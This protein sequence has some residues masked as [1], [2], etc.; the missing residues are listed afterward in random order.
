MS[1]LPT[2]AQ[3]VEPHARRES[4]VRTG[5]AIA[6]TL[7]LALGA[8]AIPAQA[9]APG[10]KTQAAVPGPKPS[11][12]PGGATSGV[13]TKDPSPADRA[14]AQKAAAAAAAQGVA[15]RPYMGWSSWSLQATKYPGVN[16]N[17]NASF[18]NEANVLQQVDALATK[19]KPYGYEYVNIDAGWS[20]NYDWALNF[21]GYAREIASPERFP[22]GMKYV[23]DAIHAKGLK[24][25][26]YLTVGLNKPVYGNGAVPIWNASGCTT[27]DIVYPDLRTTNGWDGAYKIDFSKPC[28]QKYIDSQAQLIADWGYDFLKFDGVGPGSFRGGENYNNIPD[29]AAW[30]AAIAKTGRPIEFLLSWSLDRN[31]AADW[32]RYSNGWRID[33]DVECY[34]DTLV[35]WNNS[36][37]IRWDD[38]PGWTPWAG[39][40]G[41]NNLDSLNVGNGE[42]DGLTEDERQSYMTLWAISA[43][44]L[45]A[46]DD[47][48]KLDAY[49]LSLLTNR[50]VIA[51]DQQG[52]PARP[53]T[54]TGSA[55]V[56]G[57]KNVDGT[58]TIALFNMGS[59]PAQVTANWSSFGFGGKAAVRDLWQ[60]KELGGYDGSISA[61]LPSHGSRL[62]KVTPK[63]GAVK[64]ASYEAEASTNTLVRGA[65][66]A[67][68]AN[69]SG[70]AKAGNLYNGGALRIN[71]VTVPKT[72]TYQVN[73]RYTTND[74]RSATI[75]ANGQNAVT[76][77]FPPSGGWD[78]PATLT[79]AM[80][81][82]VGAN[83]IEIDSTTPVYSPDIDKIE[84]PL[85]VR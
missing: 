57:M 22:H 2:I 8:G 30:Q 62:F 60:H 38:V 25:G 55:Q 11:P 74:P 4:R 27:A 42:M 17:G 24:A 67:G 5:V 32:K 3:R 64:M 26:I 71:G 59:F 84:V 56:W 51:V 31:Y 37:K 43:A 49:G 10:P 46:G 52:I 79:V 21:D 9:V 1:P 76:L 85:T 53:V 77:A 33:T 58:Y 54:P 78:I 83:T 48:T 7:T 45:Y 15:D 80:Q 75:S 12:A 29:V 69:C 39:P 61:T 65:S 66:V 73:I 23:A 6:A 68:C 70:G 41:W 34:C 47:L 81:L 28:A 20:T 36:V 13:T 82:H 14:A 40:G 35:T 16:P 50:E 44:P 18:L 63:D 72:G 19:L